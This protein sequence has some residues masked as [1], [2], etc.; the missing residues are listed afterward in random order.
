MLASSYGTVLRLLEI[1]LLSPAS[2][3]NLVCKVC[4]AW[5]QEVLSLVRRGGLGSRHL[6]RSGLEEVE[7]GQGAVSGVA[8]AAVP[9]G[10]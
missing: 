2:V 3:N 10:E 7:H 9:G 1:Y 5:R 6:V 8:S 4:R